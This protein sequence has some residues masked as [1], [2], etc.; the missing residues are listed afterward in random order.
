MVQ[1]VYSESRYKARNHL[2]EHECKIA[3]HIQTYLVG[4]NQKRA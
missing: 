1:G 4:L 3:T 2:Y